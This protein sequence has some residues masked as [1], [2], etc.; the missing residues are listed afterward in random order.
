VATPVRRERLVP[1]KVEAIDAT[2]AGDCYDGAFLCGIPAHR[3]CLSPPAPTPMSPPRSRRRAMARSRPCRAAPMSRPDGRGA[4]KA[5]LMSVPILT[6]AGELLARYD[7]LISD[8]WGVV[9]DGV[10]ALE[11][12]CAALMALSRGGRGGGAALERAGAVSAGRRRARRASACRARPGTRL[13]T[14]GDVTQGADRREPSP[15]RSFISAGRSDRAMF[16][17]PTSNSSAKTRPI[18]SSRPSSTTTAPRRRSNTARCWSALPRAACPSSAAIPISS[19]M[20]AR[21]SCPALGRWR[22]SMRSSAASRRLGRQ[23]LSPGL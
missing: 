13:V 17:G 21:I 1:I 15:P 23:A 10:W 16:D 11:P 5:F 12:A 14:S 2:G 18:S 3:R 6:E 20:S 22:R 9:H 7:V 4:K 19:S 8:V